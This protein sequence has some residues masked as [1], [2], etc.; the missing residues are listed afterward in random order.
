MDTPYEANRTH[1]TSG[2]S[3]Y[4]R[5]DTHPRHE[6]LIQQ[7]VDRRRP[8]VHSWQPQADRL[9]RWL[10]RR[11]DLVVIVTLVGGIGGFAFGT[12]TPPRFTATTDM[13]VDPAKL[14]IV[15]DDIYDSGA[16]R[17]AQLLDAEGKLRILTSGNVLA[18]V[19]ADLDLQTDPE[20][21]PPAT[22]SLFGFGGGGTTVETDPM[23]VAQRN[24]YGHIRARRED[25]SFIVSLSVSSVDPAKTVRISDSIVRA[26]LAELAQAD[27]D[28]AAKSAQALIDRLA[29][30][31]AD[32]N[33][34]EE[35]V[36]AFKRQ[37]QLQSSEGELLSARSMTQL[38]TQMLEAQ[39]RLIEAASR[40]EQLVGSAASANAAAL[41]SPTIAA[42]RAQYATAQ[43]AYQSQ[44]AVLG[45]LHP[46]LRTLRVQAEAL[47]AQVDAETRRLVDAAKVEFD[48]AKS[49]V[50][51]LVAETEAARSTVSTDNEAQ[52]QLRE[53]ERD[54]T[55]ASAIYEAYLARAREVTE[56]QSIDTSNVRVITPA[57]VPDSRSW[58]P[59]TMQTI[60]A[61]AATG[62]VVALLLAVALGFWTDMRKARPQEV[63]AQ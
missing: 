20:F 48:E 15:A 39:Q 17:E 52:V 1:E 6:R 14:Q 58:P 4:A 32:V 31:R 62:L 42:L 59:R 8:V 11:I 44:A 22:G 3:R 30:M 60:V 23:L 45:T 12:F 36:E 51:D 9:V 56:R 43:Q 21:V 27:A 41:Q 2:T 13:L 34:A 10:R 33:A 38:N 61:G 24:L 28:G 63:P 49:A 18:R 57:T 53:L 40:Y 50:A 16:A 54:A 25:R 47:A 37:N 7:F 55:A 35:R 46:T 19:V 26:F 5:L 29:E